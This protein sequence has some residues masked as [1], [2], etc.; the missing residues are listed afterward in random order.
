MD[1]ATGTIGLRALFDNKDE[2]LWPGLIVSLKIVLRED[3]DVIVVPRE[4][5][6]MSQRGNFVFIVKDGVAKMQP[7]TVGR[8]VDNETIVLTGL[9]G[10]EQVIVDGQLLVVNG[11]P[12]QPRPA[13]SSQTGDA[14]PK[15][16]L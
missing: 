11:G 3:K 16:A 4:A 8:S 5:V 2:L 7:V 14:S 15:R 13:R 12:V 10:Q 9:E 6:Q 1:N